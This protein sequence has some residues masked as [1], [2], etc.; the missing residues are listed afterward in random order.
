MFIFWVQMEVC[1]KFVCLSHQFCTLQHSFSFHA[2]DSRSFT[3][4]CVVVVAM[5]DS[6]STLCKIF[7]QDVIFPEGFPSE[8]ASSMGVCLLARPELV[9]HVSYVYIV[10]FLFND[11]AVSVGKSWWW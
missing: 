1:C 11:I 8:N 7:P 9:Q 10:S 6:L 2:F 3:G 4:E 5:E